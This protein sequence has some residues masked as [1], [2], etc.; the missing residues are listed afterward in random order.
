MVGHVSRIEFVEKGT[1][2]VGAA[3]TLRSVGQSL[4]KNNCIACIYRGLYHIG[5]HPLQRANILWQILRKIAL[6]A[7]RNTDKP[8]ITRPGWSQHKSHDS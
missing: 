8:T 1:P 3:P 5:R 6:V 7:T 4:G 2:F